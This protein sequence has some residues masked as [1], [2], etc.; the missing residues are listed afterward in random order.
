MN[1]SAPGDVHPIVCLH[2]LFLDP[3]MFDNIAEAGGDQY[4]FIAPELLG[5]ATRLDEVSSTVTMKQV[6]DDV[7]NFID[8]LGFP[9]FSLIGASM[10]GDVALR[11]AARRPW[12]VEKLVL[13]GSSA[14]GQ[15]QKDLGGFASLPSRIEQEGFSPE[16]VDMV[17]TIMFGATT[18]AD[19]SRRDI[20]ELWKGQLTELSPKLVHAVRAVFERE[21]AIQHLRPGEGRNAHRVRHRR[22]WA[23]PGVVR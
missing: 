5:H 10:G 17:M 18:L 9:R 4:R 8:D 15:T 2:S 20:H 22:P 21:G 11:I 19:H 14:R 7:L 16:I 12:S 13:L 23:A 3:R 6:T 1:D